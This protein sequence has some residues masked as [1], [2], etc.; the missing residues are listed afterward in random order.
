[1]IWL[2]LR[3]FNYGTLLFRSR[4]SGSSPILFYLR[5]CYYFSTP[6]MYIKGVGYCRW[7]IVLR[8]C[9]LFGSLVGNWIDKTDRLTGLFFLSQPCLFYNECWIRNHVLQWWSGAC[10]SRIYQ[11]QT[12]GGWC[13]CFSLCEVKTLSPWTPGGPCFT[14]EILVSYRI[15]I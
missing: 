14:L 5:Q 13:G 12:L 3:H 15:Y 8:G 10:C 1:M 4:C 11:L 9:V 6:C 7:F 2:F